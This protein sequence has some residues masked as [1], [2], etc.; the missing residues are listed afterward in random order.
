MEGAGMKRIVVSLLATF[1][2]AAAAGLAGQASALPTFTTPTFTQ[3]GGPP[4]TD[5]KVTYGITD[6]APDSFLMLATM[7]LKFTFSAYENDFDFGTSLLDDFLGSWMVTLRQRDVTALTGGGYRVL[8]L[9]H[10]L[11]GGVAAGGGASDN[12]YYLELDSV[13]KIPVPASL[14]LLLSALA[15]TAGLRRGSARRDPA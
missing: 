4:P 11:A 3:V 2:F 15:G 10:T 7:P 8:G 5:V 12:D 14:L 13:A 9:M 1:G 6:L